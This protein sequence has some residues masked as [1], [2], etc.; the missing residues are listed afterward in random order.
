MQVPYVEQWEEESPEFRNYFA[1]QVPDAIPI[2]GYDYT[3]VSRNWRADTV[4]VGD[5]RLRLEFVDETSSIR[6]FEIP[7]EEDAVA[8]G[9]PAIGEASAILI[10]FSLL[11][12]AER[13]RAHPREASGQ[14]AIPPSILRID[15]ENER[16]RLTFIPQS[17]NVQIV[18]G[19]PTI[20]SFNGTYYFSLKPEPD[21]IIP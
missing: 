20:N 1:L 3:Y 13:A 8:G 16:I 15:A 5:R 10:E 9:A 17:L 18:N 6:V 21:A 14:W 19:E 12:A 11:A 7:D 2:D 4:W